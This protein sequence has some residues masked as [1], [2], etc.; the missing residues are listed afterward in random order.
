MLDDLCF[1]CVAP[2]SI[3]WVAASPLCKSFE[4]ARFNTLLARNIMSDSI[5][6][7]VINNREV[8]S[9]GINFAYSR[10]I[11]QTAFP[12]LLIDTAC[13]I[14]CFVVAYSS[15]SLFEVYSANVSSCVW[16]VLVLLGAMVASFLILELYDPVG[17]HPVYEFRQM[18]LCNSVLYIMTTWAM[19]YHQNPHWVITAI[20]FPMLLISTPV[21]RA[22]GRSLLARTKW[23]GVRCLVFSADRRIEELYPNHLRNGY[24]GLRPVGFVQDDVPGSCSEDIRQHHLGKVSNANSISKANDAHVSLV[25]RRGRTENE[26]SGFIKTNLKS[27]VRIVTQPDDSRLPSIQAIGRNGG[28]SFEDRLMLPSSRIAKRLVD[29]AISCSVLFFGLPFFVLIAVWLKIADP[30]PLFF[31]HERICKNGKRFKAWKFRTMAVNSDEILEKHL[32]ENPAAKAEWEATYKL[33][34]D[35]RV[36]LPGHILRKTSLDELPQLWNILVGEMSL[37]GPRPI[38]VGEVERYASILE[39]YIRVQPGLTGLWQVSGRNLT[40]YDRRVELDDFYVRNWSVWFDFYIIG[41]TF[42]TVLLREG[43]F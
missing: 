32:E 26:L 30:G 5:S 33:Q 37:V 18:T 17:M 1:R 29:L 8:K 6:T 22:V 12:L 23:W 34:N 38:V 35:P 7:A 41:R 4:F 19:F 13:L 31:G 10:Q 40:T 3:E 2:V 11:L 15:G 25:H 36:S 9:Q 20:M 28:I 27:F 42:K 43:A 39:N 24:L 21:C 14:C 16:L